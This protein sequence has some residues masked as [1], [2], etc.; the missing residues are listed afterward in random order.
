MS[1]VALHHRLNV[2]PVRHA[3]A[4]LLVCTLACAA[5]AAPPK[6][7]N[8]AVLNFQM[9]SDTPRWQ[10]LEKGLADRLITDFHQADELAVVG[11]DIMQQL[12]KRMQWVPEM[13]SDPDKLAMIQKALK[14]TYAVS[15]VYE[16]TGDQLLL[17]ASIINLESTK[18]V[19]R[20][21]VSGKA[22]DALELTRRLSATLL[23]WFLKRKAEDILETLPV[24]TRSVDAASALYR[25]I[26][27]Y[28]DGRYSEAW[29]LFRR[30][31]RSD[32]DY[33]EA[34]YWVGKMFYFMDRY[35]HARRAFEQFIYLDITHPRVGDAMREY[36]HT[37]EKCDPPLETLLR[38]Y[39]VLGDR[40]PDVWI[41]GDAQYMPGT[42]I[43]C[44][45]WLRNKT[46]YALAEAGRCEEAARLAEVSG[47]GNTA[48][49]LAT[50]SLKRHYGQT[51]D[52]W[53]PS[54]LTAWDI[55][56]DGIVRFASGSSVMRH[57]VVERPIRKQYHP[58]KHHATGENIMYRAILS[59]RVATTEFHLMAPAGHTF[60]S[61]NVW[62]EVNGAVQHV[63][64]TLSHSARGDLGSRRLTGEFSKKTAATFA[65]LPVSGWLHL[66]CAVEPA[67]KQKASGT[68]LRALHFEAR[69]SA[70]PEKPGAIDV[71]CA[72]GDQFQVD[73]NGR[74]GRRGTG[75]IGP[76]SPGA[77][78]LEFRPLDNSGPHAPWSTTVT[79]KPGETASSTGRLVWRPDSPWNTWQTAG[80]VGTTATVPHPMDGD[81]VE[82]PTLHADHEAIRIV[83][84]QAGD[85]WKTVSTNGKQFATP[86]RIRLPVSSGWTERCPRVLRDETGRFVLFF[87]SNRGHR[88][89]Q[90]LYVCWSR[91]FIHWSAPAMVLNEPVSSSYSVIQDNIGRFLVA[92]T[93]KLNRIHLMASRDLHR[94]RPLG[95]ILHPEGFCLA[96]G[97][98]CLTQRDDGTLELD[99]AIQVRQGIEIAGQELKIWIW[100]TVSADGVRWA[101]PQ[102]VGQTGIARHLW[103][104]R[105]NH[106]DRPVIA[107]FAIASRQ[108][109]TGMVFYRDDCTR[110]IETR[111][112]GW[113][114]FRKKGERQWHVGAPMFWQIDSS[115]TLFCRGKAGT[116][117]Q[118]RVPSSVAQGPGT[119]VAHP[120][121]G[122]L[123]A[124]MSPKGAFDFPRPASGPFLMSGPTLHPLVG[125]EP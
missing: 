36:L 88:R 43:R 84:S 78:R 8:V 42:K 49:E 29:L 77:H 70:T 81:F 19:A 67:E 101:R 47:W 45:D 85:L 1:T 27:L 69:V 58:I 41:Y 44:H 89:G 116:W 20:R 119:L 121:W 102:L 31:S 94:W 115:L 37:W 16:I 90:L 32:P 80:L 79:V 95:D 10:W 12:A 91:D 52:L 48:C 109:N 107:C 40:H 38:V 7:A 117:R 39:R 35:K 59:T 98:L 54:W 68:P 122:Y 56:G 13:L 62:P 26:G 100:Q 25:G 110:A 113:Y 97:G 73:V 28:D 24:W 111:T 14:P 9:K 66:R 74:P 64:L 18:E 53:T 103:L 6:S 63:T 11:R 86:E 55:W 106:G 112:D 92:D 104:C 108:L 82:R 30:A 3:A 99:F 2:C 51:G 5:G 22:K 114:F 57:E 83:W 105:L 125:Q 60:D 124:W 33:V 118:S 72:N 93:G 23:E 61:I 87:L 46:A 17:K 65:P 21:E 96:D 71:T 15:G 50:V 34:R 123:L 76:L 4:C 75:V 120:K